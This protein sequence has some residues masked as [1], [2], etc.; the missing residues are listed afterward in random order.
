M[1]PEDF[2]KLLNKFN[3]FRGMKTY[4][5]TDIHTEH[6]NAYDHYTATRKGLQYE[7]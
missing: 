4:H 2:E 1:T 7:A 3:D 6:L 5:D